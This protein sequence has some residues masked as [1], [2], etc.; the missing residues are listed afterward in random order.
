[1]RVTFNI[2]SG[3]EDPKQAVEL[4][5]KFEALMVEYGLQGTTR[6]DE[7]SKRAIFNG[8]YRT[9]EKEE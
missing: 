3:S 2:S 8:S 5:E 9:E 7:Y 4:R 1:M 6:G